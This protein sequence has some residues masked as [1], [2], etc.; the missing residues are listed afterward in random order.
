MQHLLHL[1]LKIL[2]KNWTFFVKN[3]GQSEVTIQEDIRIRIELENNESINILIQVDY[4]LSKILQ[5]TVA[6]RFLSEAEKKIL[7][8]QA[9]QYSQNIF[10]Q[11][12]DFFHPEPF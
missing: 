5:L 12:D 11:N 10:T 2:N 9:E 3:K 8:L 7:L 6:S 1:R 4:M